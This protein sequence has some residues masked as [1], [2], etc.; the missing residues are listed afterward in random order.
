VGSTDILADPSAWPDDVIVMTLDRVG[1]SAGP[2]LRLF[3]T[4]LGRTPGRRVYAA[5]GVR[6][7]EDL[8]ALSRLG[9]AGALVASSLHDG[10]LTRADLARIESPPRA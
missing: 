6:G 9:A 1:T 2:N 8:F 10:C 5:G 4:I 3:S 7:V